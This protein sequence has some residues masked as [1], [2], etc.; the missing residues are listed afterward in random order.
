MALLKYKF[1]DI[2]KPIDFQ[3]KETE[4]IFGREFKHIKGG[5]YKVVEP[6]KVK[7]SEFWKLLD[8]YQ[9][10]LCVIYKEFE[11]FQKE[12]GR[13]NKGI[14]PK[15]D[16][17]Y[18]SMLSPLEI[19]MLLNDLSG[20]QTV[21]SDREI[22]IVYVFNTDW[23]IV[24]RRYSE[25]ENIL[26]YLIENTDEKNYIRYN[27]ENTRGYDETLFLDTWN[28]ISPRR[29]INAD[30]VPDDDYIDENTYKQSPKI[31]HTQPDILLPINVNPENKPLG[32]RP[33]MNF[34][35]FIG[36]LIEDGIYYFGEDYRYRGRYSSADNCEIDL[37]LS[38]EEPC[39]M[40]YYSTDFHPTP[41]VGLR[42]FGVGAKALQRLQE[43]EPYYNNLYYHAFRIEKEEEH[44]EHTILD[45]AKLEE[46]YK[47]VESHELIIKEQIEEDLR[48]K[49]ESREIELLVEGTKD[50][51]IKDLT[52]IYKT[53][54]DNP[55]TEK[56]DFVYKQGDYI[57]VEQIKYESTENTAYHTKKSIYLPIITSLCIKK[58]IK[59]NCGM[60][61]ELALT[62]LD[63]EQ[64]V[65]M[66]VI[67]PDYLQYFINEEIK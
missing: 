47:R 38:F 16:E 22:E 12:N 65:L 4:T 46:E 37:N 40:L 32:Q 13:L 53:L 28:N 42:Y 45:F 34:N 59:L 11:V 6:Y 62:V 51:D 48:K 9:E 29:F 43:L 18:E 15:E 58:S 61:Y 26:L 7:L 5:I 3:Y 19:D 35:G 30:F 60:E 1:K 24:N 36:V 67:K 17:S 25:V 27:I 55:V 10:N 54:L 63:R 21:D 2:T 33:F 56:C 14:E 44:R 20:N 8:D 52:I 50:I 41:Y 49:L 66:N 39:G 31:V 57:Y 23:C 64:E